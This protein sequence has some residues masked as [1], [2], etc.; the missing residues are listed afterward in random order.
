MQFVSLVHWTQACVVVLQ[1]DRFGVPEQF[2]LVRHWTQ[3]LAVVSQYGVGAAQSPLVVHFET[4]WCVLVL[5]TWFALPQFASVR[6]ATHV[7]VAVSQ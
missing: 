4:H 5:H 2:V 1:T 7:L 3:R 6:Q